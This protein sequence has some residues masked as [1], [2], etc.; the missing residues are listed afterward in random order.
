MEGIATATMSATRS[1][2]I[3]WAMRRSRFRTSTW[4]TAPARAAGQRAC[5][6]ATPG[7]G[8]HEDSLPRRAGWPHDRRPPTQETHGLDD[9]HPAFQGA[10]GGPVARCSLRWESLSD[11]PAVG[12]RLG[13]PPA[14]RMWMLVVP[15]QFP[16][17]YLYA[18]KVLT[19]IYI[20][21]DTAL[22]SA[23]AC[24]RGCH[25]QKGV[26]SL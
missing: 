17:I 15:L 2:W 22:S 4:R 10:T 19:L 20:Y 21:I 24:N 3:P 13:D 25:V 7:S 16:Y 5:A 18:C 26:N 14:L 1:C 12:R 23:R 8:G 6:G 11:R 9:G